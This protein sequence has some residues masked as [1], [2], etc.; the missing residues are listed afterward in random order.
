MSNNKVD[1][2][3][4]AND[5]PEGFKPIP[6]ST[7]TLRLAVP[8]RPGWHRHWF[9]GN[10][11]RLAR[12]RQAGYRMVQTH[13]VALNNFDLGGDAMTTGNSDLGSNVSV[14]SGDDLDTTG[15]PGRL[16]LMECP[17]EYY[18]MG[19][20]ILDERNENVA[21]ALRGGKI[22]SESDAPGDENARYIKKGTPIPDLFNPNKRRRT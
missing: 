10:P 13:E 20:K 22:G 2:N 16:Y 8:E 14:I 11:E 17:L 18:E 9:R 12:A 4:P 1:A 3:N 19:K 7:G 15:Q 6:M 21:E 5:Y